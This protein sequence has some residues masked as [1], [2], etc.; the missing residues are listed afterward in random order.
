MPRVKRGVN[1]PCSSS[2]ESFKLVYY[3]ARSRNFTVLLFKP[4][5]KAGQYVYRDCRQKNGPFPVQLGLHVL[6][7]PLVQMVFSVFT[8]VSSTV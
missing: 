1:C 4:V 7:L 3:G 6:M 5:T 2:K 8:A